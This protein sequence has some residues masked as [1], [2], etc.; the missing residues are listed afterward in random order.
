MDTSVLP[1]GALAPFVDPVALAIVVGGTLL[2]LV[3]RTPRAD[4]AR[5]FAALAVLAR[6]PWKADTTLDQI[7]ALDRIARKHGIV[8]LNRSV[9][10]D[11]DVAEAVTDIVDGAGPETVRR[12]IGERALARSERHLAAVEVWSGIAEIAP[13][14]GMVGTLIGLVRMFMVMTDP[15]RI[16]GAMAVALLTTLYGAVIAS[17]IASPIAARLRRL[18]RIEAFERSR[19]EA[20]L[21]ELARRERPR[22]REAVA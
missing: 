11:G 5:A 12:L 22:L 2:A 1:I 13:A 17:L 9:I 15:T 6:R 10:R 19:L 14:M 20:P 4:L 7:A 8:A 18:A 16:G 21:I 3:I